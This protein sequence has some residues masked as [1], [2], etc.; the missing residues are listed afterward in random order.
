MIA[1][2]K[3]IVLCMLFTLFAINGSA[4]QRTAIEPD[5]IVKV[6]RDTSSIKTVILPLK[7]DSISKQDVSPAAVVFKPD[8]KK[9]IIYSVLFPGMGQIYN[10]KYWKL[11]LV[12]GGFLGLTY[13][14]TW[15][16]GYYNDYSDAYKAVMSENPMSP[17]NV[18]KW[19]DF[20]PIGDSPSNYTADTAKSTYE[21][22]FK[23]KKDF[24]RRNRDLSI[25]G[26][27]ALYGLCIIDAYVDA[28]LF[29]FDISPDISMRVEPTMIRNNN[30]NTKLL[31][32]QDAF[33]VQCSLKF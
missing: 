6:E 14:V 11:P 15:N 24:Y 32:N 19:Q 33:G 16:G 23:R 10:R 21:G 25:I 27:V 31:A 12:Y 20:L 28:Q 9:A 26:M 29:D 18:A 7:A 3:K 2:I 8:P 30:N 4:Q 1:D 13:A 17:E 22:P 5:S